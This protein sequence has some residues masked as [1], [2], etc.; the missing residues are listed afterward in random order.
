MTIVTQTLGRLGLQIAITACLLLALVA[1]GNDDTG[2]LSNA[3]SPT[4]TAAPPVPTIPRSNLPAPVERAIETAAHDRGVSPDA[5]GLV[6]FAEVQWNDTSLDCPKPG[7]LYA[8]VIT[9][10]YDV[11]LIIDGHEHEYHTDM[12]GAVVQC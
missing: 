5:I 3:P 6:S 12:G 4:A 9:P 10:G 1:C 7:G 2:D 11:H 8:Q